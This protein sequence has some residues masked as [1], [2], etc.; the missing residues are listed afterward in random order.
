LWSWSW[1]GY[2]IEGVFA[3]RFG[4]TPINPT[5]KQDPREQKSV[6]WPKIDAINSW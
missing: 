6:M 5:K 1:S 4:A 3:G 2:R